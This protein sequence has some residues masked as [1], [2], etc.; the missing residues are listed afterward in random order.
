MA[1]VVA[2]TVSWPGL[3]PS[4]ATAETL[5]SGLVKPAVSEI[6]AAPG[7][8]VSLDVEIVKIHD[9]AKAAVYA[10]FTRLSSI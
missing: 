9:S 6:V 7:P 2:I 5:N 10:A 1:G 8:L 3:R 4:T